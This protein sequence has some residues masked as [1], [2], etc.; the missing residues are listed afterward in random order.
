MSFALKK[1]YLRLR[2]KPRGFESPSIYLGVSKVESVVPGGCGERQPVASAY[3]IGRRVPRAPGGTWLTTTTTSCWERGLG[4][5]GG[6][7]KKMFPLSPSHR[8]FHIPWSQSWRAYSYLHVDKSISPTFIHFSILKRCPDCS[9]IAKVRDGKKKKIWNHKVGS[10][11]DLGL[12]CVRA[13]GTWVGTS[14]ISLCSF[15]PR[16]LTWGR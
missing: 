13:G 1:N 8:P 3:R 2:R 9:E 16:L 5:G 7:Q 4:G 10:W 6:G 14:V 11:V 12:G 15:R